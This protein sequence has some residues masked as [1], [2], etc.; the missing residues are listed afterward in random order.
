MLT[1]VKRSSTLYWTVLL[2]LLTMAPTVRSS[3]V[4]WETEVTRVTRVTRGRWDHRV[5]SVLLDQLVNQ[6]SKVN[7]AR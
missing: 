1:A 6:G 5:L 3:K 4:Q 7:M 2:L